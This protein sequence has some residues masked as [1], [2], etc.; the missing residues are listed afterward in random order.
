MHI[1]NIIM[2]KEDRAIR[3]TIYFL[4]S[5]MVNK[6]KLHLSSTEFLCF[7]EL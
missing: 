3:T 6:F 5:L 1:Y 4:L 2:F 7:D